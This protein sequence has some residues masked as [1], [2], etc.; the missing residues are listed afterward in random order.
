MGPIARSPPLPP[1]ARLIDHLPRGHGPTPCQRPLTAHAPLPAHRY[2]RTDKEV[3]EGAQA[4]SRGAPEEGRRGRGVFRLERLERVGGRGG[5]RQGTPLHTHTQGAHVRVVR[6]RAAEGEETQ[7]GEGTNAGDHCRWRG[8]QIT[9][10]RAV[11]SA[12]LGSLFASP[13][14]ALCRRGAIRTAAPPLLPSSVAVLWFLFCCATKSM[15]AAA[16]ERSRR[17]PATCS[18][19]LFFCC[20]DCS[21]APLRLGFTLPPLPPSPRLSLPRTVAHASPRPET[22]C[23]FDFFVPLLSSLLLLL[24][25]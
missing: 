16:L 5:P 24:Q 19:F 11:P 7:R 1:P 23:S 18:C 4:R 10:V 8:R 20:A 14:P 22:G 17:R 12:R 25:F 15:P 3:E 9:H 6:L 2:A 21:L 13:L